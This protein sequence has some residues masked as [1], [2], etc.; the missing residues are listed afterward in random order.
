MPHNT[1]EAAIGELSMAFQELEN[2][3]I[4]LFARLTDPNHDTVG[5]IIASQ[6]PF[7]KLTAVL[8]AIFRYRV[9][10]PTLVDRCDS[11]LK[12]G[13]QLEQ[14][15]N[16]YIHSFY[17]WR[18]ISGE[19]ITYERIKNRI[20]PGK[21]FSPDYEMLDTEKV[22]KISEQFRILIAGIDLFFEELQERGIIS[23]R[24]D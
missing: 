5:V 8:A 6:L 17:D 1:A 20:K 11:L 9:K 4:W 3:L 18:E 7:G 23:R 16:T 14:Q 2:S 19:R 21:G 12:E 22:G 24:G 10:D 15:R 13:Q